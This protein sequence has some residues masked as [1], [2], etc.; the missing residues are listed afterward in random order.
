MNKFKFGDKVKCPHETLVGDKFYVVGRVV[1]VIGHPNGTRYQ[2]KIM[3]DFT[4]KELELI[5][6]RD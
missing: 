5:D 6:E 4:E 2:I 3:G 1:N